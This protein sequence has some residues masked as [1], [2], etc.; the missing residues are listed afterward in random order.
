MI[1]LAVVGL[2][3]WGRRHIASAEADRRFRIVRAVD[4]RPET[5]SDLAD[6]GIAVSADLADALDDP[7]VQA[8]SLVTPHTLHARQVAACAAAG[9]HVL[10]EKPLS[11]S[12]RDARMAAGA[13][14]APIRPVSMFARRVLPSS[15]RTASCSSTSIRA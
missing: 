12:S 7:S 3:R 10:T 8:V 1:D 13:C 11:L 5:A 2:G 14:T 6:R 4:I 9:K 15:G